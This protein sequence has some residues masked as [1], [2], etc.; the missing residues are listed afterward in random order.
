MTTDPYAAPLFVDYLTAINRFV[1]VAAKAAGEMKVRH[2]SAGWVLAN[3]QMRHREQRSI[4]RMQRRLDVDAAEFKTI[5]LLN[6]HKDALRELQDLHYKLAMNRII[7]FTKVPRIV[8]IL[9]QFPVINVRQMAENAGVSEA[10]AK[11]W[12][13]AMTNA[14]LVQEDYVNGQNQYSNVNLLVIID[15]HAG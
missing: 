15:R 7:P 8:E 5:Q 11:R 1:K 9:A 13:K 6:L 4:Y 2:K 14:W 12:L 10:T 3:R